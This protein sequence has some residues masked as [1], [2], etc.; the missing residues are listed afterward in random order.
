LSFSYDGFGNLLSQQVTKGT[1]Y[2]MTLAY[3]G[4]TNRIS[5]GGYGYDANGNLTAMPYLGLTYDV[6][7]RLTRAVHTVNG[8]EEYGYDP[9]NQ[10]VWKKEANGHEWFYFYGPNAERLGAYRLSTF[11][12]THFEVGRLEMWFGGRLVVR[13]YGAAEEA[14]GVTLDR[15]GSEGRYYP[16]GEARDGGS[17]F[18]TYRRDATG[19]DYAN[20]RYYSSTVARFLTPD[21]YQA[22]GGPADPQSWNR[23]AYVQ[24]DPVNYIDPLG[25][26]RAKLVPDSHGEKV[27]QHSNGT[28]YP[29]RPTDGTQPRTPQELDEQ[30][31]D[32]FSAS[33]ERVV[34][35]DNHFSAFDLDC[36]A[37]IESHWRSGAFNNGQQRYG[38]FQW[39]EINWNQWKYAVPSDKRSDWNAENARDPVISS[40]ITLYSLEYR[41]R[42]NV[43]RGMPATAAKTSAIDAF[44]EGDATYG[45]AV[46]DCARKLEAGDFN[47]A[48]QSIRRY[49]RWVYGG[50][51]AP[52]PF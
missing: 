4:L 16:Y 8:T 19:L 15:L 39:N 27:F 42:K 3:N 49:Q 34:S 41:F 23:Y 51:S 22:S 9:R 31:F 47:G 13:S 50:R 30:Y 32:K 45:K 21:P 7:N 12:G 38:Y 17:M 1:A 43:D 35:Q 2:S 28:S 10:R 29:R 26:F 11:N 37:G 36:I 44:G 48:Y 40:T 25:L 14:T 6:Q 24:N 5:S 33:I 20:Q 46:E 18:A 52:A